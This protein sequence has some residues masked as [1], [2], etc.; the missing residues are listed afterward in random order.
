MHF[1][2]IA[3]VLATV[4][5]LSLIPSALAHRQALDPVTH[6]LRARASPMPLALAGQQLPVPV[7]AL[8]GD[9]DGLA[10]IRLRALPASGVQNLVP[11]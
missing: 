7:A 8:V 2:K 11:R 3:L 6:R 5:S 9:D 10:P 1:N 4:S